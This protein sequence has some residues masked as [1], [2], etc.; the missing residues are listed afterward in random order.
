M[1]PLN[2]QGLGATSPEIS[3]VSARTALPPKGFCWYCDQ[4]V[5]SVRR[6]CS[7]SCRHDYYEEEEEFGAS[8]SAAE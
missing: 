5:D 8:S 4:A 3:A 2:H 6:F 1:N 7:P